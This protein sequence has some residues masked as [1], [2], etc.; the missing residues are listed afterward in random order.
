MRV[1][2]QAHVR[3]HTDMTTHTH[4][5][6]I[7]IYIALNARFFMRKASPCAHS[8][9]LPVSASLAEANELCAESCSGWDFALSCR[10]LKIVA[11]MAPLDTSPLSKPENTQASA[12]PPKALC[13]PQCGVNWHLGIRKR[14]ANVKMTL[15]HICAWLA[16]CQ[17]RKNAEILPHWTALGILTALPRMPDHGI[18][19]GSFQNGM[20]NGLPNGTKHGFPNGSFTSGNMP[21]D[22][23]FPAR[24][25][26]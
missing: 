12:E 14:P 4:Y 26:F 25:G 18:T 17:W 20:V 8:E 22:D 3:T 23:V 11:L 1:Y 10:G 15:A 24:T 6:Y 9:F 21:D 7:Y 2:K 16:I 5:I 19:N 13:S